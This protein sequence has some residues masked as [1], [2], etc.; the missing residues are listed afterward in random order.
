[1]DL[2]TIFKFGGKVSAL[3]RAYK[4]QTIGDYQLMDNEPYMKIDNIQVDFNYSKID[5]SATSGRETHSNY[6]EEV[7][8]G[9]TLYGIPMNH[10]S[11]SLI[12]SLLLTNQLT[13]GFESVECEDNTI[14]L[15]KDNLSD[16]FIYDENKELVLNLTNTGNIISNP[17]LENN[18]TYTVFY[19]YIAESENSFGLASPHISYLTIELFAQ[20]NLDNQ[21]G[22]SYLKLLR[23]KLDSDIKST[24]N[25]DNS[26]NTLNLHFEV[27]DGNKKDN[28]LII[29]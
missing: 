12:Y 21:T 8:T 14:I 28:Y 16:V 3:I 9:I 22:K 5:A 24:I 2:S 1:M 13:S 7:L 20:G 15:Q 29:G 4:A 11:S 26:V 25:Y 17:L 18:K 19:N 10:R 23:C 27:I 6:N